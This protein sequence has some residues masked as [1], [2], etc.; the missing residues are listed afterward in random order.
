MNPLLVDLLALLQTAG[1]GTTGVTMFGSKEPDSPDECVT[2]YN[3]GGISDNRLSET[4]NAERYFFQV[5]V[6]SG[7][8]S[9][10]YALIDNITA[11][12]TKNQ[13]TVGTTRYTF[14][15]SG[16]P[17]DLPRDTK[18]RCIVVSNFTCLRFL[19]A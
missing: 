3:T 5:R 13:S 17:I 2:L 4:E 14:N 16:L 11:E 18:N 9:D 15:Q 10:A 12:F 7:D 19:T 1:I 6:R 8:Y